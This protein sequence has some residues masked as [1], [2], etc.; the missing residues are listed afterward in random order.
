[1]RR[2]AVAAAA[3]VNLT[4]VNAPTNGFVTVW[5][6]AATSTPLPNVSA[7]NFR[8]GGAVNNGAVAGDLQNN[9]GTVVPGTTTVV[10][11]D[12]RDDHPV[13]VT[14]VSGTYYVVGASGLPTPAGRVE[15][16]SC[17]EP[18]ATTA[19]TKFL[20]LSRATLCQGCHLK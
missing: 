20:R 18:H 14:Y 5:P 12:L 3:V 9:L 8:A 2:G 19:N 13:G 7:I 11:L 1:M 16:S 17:H 15:C 6:C 4:V 10:G